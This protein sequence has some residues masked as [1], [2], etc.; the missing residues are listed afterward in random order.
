VSTA[1]A[2][3]LVVG[4]LLVGVPIDIHVRLPM[5]PITSRARDK[6]APVL[7][8]FEGQ[9]PHATAFGGVP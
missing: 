4:A 2:A 3:A 8:D 1:T 6:S 9:V 5:F 7:L